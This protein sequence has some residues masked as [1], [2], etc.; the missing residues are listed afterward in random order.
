[1]PDTWRKIPE[2]TLNDV[3]TNGKEVRR[4]TS[5]QSP[6]VH[7]FV[8]YL[9]AKESYTPKLIRSNEAFEYFEYVPGKTINLPWPRVM[10]DIKWIVEIAKWLSKHHKTA[11]H[12]KFIKGDIS[13][14]GPVEDL[15]LFPCHGDLGPWNFLTDE[16]TLKSV[17]DWD[18]LRPGKSTDDLAQLATEHVPLRPPEP[19]HPSPFSQAELT[20]RLD[21]LLDTY[22]FLKT[23]KEFL[24]LCL[25]Y[26]KELE[27]DI[28]KVGNQSTPPFSPCMMKLNQRGEHMRYAQ[29]AEYIRE[30]WF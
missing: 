23:R 24:I 27:T 25:N 22:G 5:V 8:K 26:L 16:G 18:L 7:R 2:G 1:M 11:S 21:L 3:W 12:F 13:A 10:T 4:K 17:I 9:N 14:W 15:S 19:E 20:E 30:H 29:T 28:A 6:L